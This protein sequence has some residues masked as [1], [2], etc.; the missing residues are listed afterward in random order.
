MG[1][2]PQGWCQNGWFAVGQ[3]QLSKKQHCGCGRYFQLMLD[4]ILLP[5]T[6][7]AF[8]GIDDDADEALEIGQAQVLSQNQAEPSPGKP[9]LTLY[10]WRGPTLPAS[11][12]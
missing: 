2:T 6:Q 10:T 4:F 1:L 5:A 9:H 12:P 3:G 8:A 7:E 11:V